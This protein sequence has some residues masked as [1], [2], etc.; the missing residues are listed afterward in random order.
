ML[1]QGRAFVMPP[2]YAGPGAEAGGAG[3]EP[4]RRFSVV[5]ADRPLV[6]PEQGCSG[7]TTGV[8][9]SRR[10]ETGHAWINGRRIDVTSPILD[11]CNPIDVSPRLLFYR[12]FTIAV[13]TYSRGG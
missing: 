8:G 13:I 10:G 12:S 4:P 2:E 3:R 11:G 9:A 1:P 7:S 5:R 6:R